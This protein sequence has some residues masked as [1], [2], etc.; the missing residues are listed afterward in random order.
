MIPALESAFI[1]RTFGLF[2]EVRKFA[3]LSFE[4]AFNICNKWLKDGKIGGFDISKNN[5]LLFKSY[6]H[7]PKWVK[8]DDPDFNEF[9]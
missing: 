2:C 7:L 4:S 9:S 1:V 6:S 3:F 5:V 8:W